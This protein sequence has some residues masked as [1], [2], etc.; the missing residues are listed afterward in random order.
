MGLGQSGPGSCREG[1]RKDCG[2]LAAR[3]WP[4]WER[5]HVYCHKSRP[6]CKSK[7]WSPGWAQKEWTLDAAI[8]VSCPSPPPLLHLLPSLQ[9]RHYNGWAPIGACQTGVGGENRA[10]EVGHRTQRRNWLLAPLGKGWCL[11]PRT[12]GFLPQQGQKRPGAEE[13][14]ARRRTLMPA[15]DNTP[16]CGFLPLPLLL[17]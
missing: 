6:G 17:P 10:R 15:V 13:T 1:Q 5:G 2:R 8:R 4:P 11:S 9:H 3:P 12:P 14:D 7:Q 16:P